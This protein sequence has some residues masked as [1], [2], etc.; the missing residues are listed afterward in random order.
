[1][2]DF[3]GKVVFLNFWASWCGPCRAEMPAMQDLLAEYGDELVVIAANNQEAY[4]PA[5]SFID[6]LGVNYTEF[7][8]DPSGEIVDAYKVFTMPTSYF[9]DP[10][11]RI[12]ALHLG[13]ITYEEMV[14]RFEEAQNASARR[15]SLD[16]E[17]LLQRVGHGPAC[18][19]RVL[20][21]DNAAHG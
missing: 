19:P 21:G 12:S 8:L 18:E 17:D 3:R 15:L 4:R 11:G 6:D 9:I 5:K 14:E 7:A 10:E 13:Q 16:D 20:T 1:M 2:S